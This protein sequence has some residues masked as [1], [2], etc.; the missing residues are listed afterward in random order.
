MMT[1]T[2]VAPDM[3]GLTLALGN[4]GAGALPLP[5]NRLKDLDCEF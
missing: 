4:D 1:A 3:P 2:H 5:S